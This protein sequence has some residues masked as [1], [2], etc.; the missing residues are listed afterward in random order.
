MSVRGISEYYTLHIIHLPGHHRI[1]FI[2]IWEKRLFLG[3][4]RIMNSSKK[5]PNP[6]ISVL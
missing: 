1:L 4:L 2:G 3:P 6:K 5:L